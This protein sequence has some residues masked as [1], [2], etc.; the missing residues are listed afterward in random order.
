VSSELLAFY[1][2][3]KNVGLD[4]WGIIDC[5]SILLI[6]DMAPDLVH[7]LVEVW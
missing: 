4:G 2:G 3:K 6:K 7:D 5:F 1:V